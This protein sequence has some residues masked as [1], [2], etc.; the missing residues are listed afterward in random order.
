MGKQQGLG[1]GKIGHSIFSVKQ[2]LDLFSTAVYLPEQLA[3]CQWLG[4]MEI[5]PLNQKHIDELKQ[6]Y[7]KHTG[8]SL[9]DQEAWNMAR[10]L[11]N[12]QRMLLNENLCKKNK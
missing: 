6:T 12:L 10:R 11:V 4:I 8:E 7:L 5:M 2:N 1:F 9:S 3:E